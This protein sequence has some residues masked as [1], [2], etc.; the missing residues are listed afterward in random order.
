MQDASATSMSCLMRRRLPEKNNI[1]P[2]LVVT[3]SCLGLRRA[4]HSHISEEMV[5]LLDAGMVLREE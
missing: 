5:G 1:T 4:T 3:V 2:T